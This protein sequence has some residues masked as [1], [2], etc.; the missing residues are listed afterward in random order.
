M[1][2]AIIIR[3]KQQCYQLYRH[4]K[5]TLQMIYTTEQRYTVSIHNLDTFAKLSSNVVD[6]LTWCL[7]HIQAHTLSAFNKRCLYTCT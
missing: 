5:D 4:V 7:S 1:F 2:F 6:P 3:S